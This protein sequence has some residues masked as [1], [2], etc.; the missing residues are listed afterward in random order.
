MKRLLLILLPILMIACNAKKNSTNPGLE[1][2]SYNIS[3][4]SGD[5]V[6]H[7]GDTLTITASASNKVGNQTLTDGFIYDTLFLYRTDHIPLT[8]D[9]LV[10]ESMLDTDFVLIPYTD[11]M[12]YSPYL[13]GSVLKGDSVFLQNDSFKMKFQLV[14]L[15][16]GL[17][18]F[19]TSGGKLS[20]G[21]GSAKVNS[22]ISN[23]NHHYWYQQVPGIDT[24][25]LGTSGYN[26]NYLFTVQ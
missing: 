22:I 3:V 20:S 15:K 10:S 1:A 9:T 24:P 5:S 11:H 25:L 21:L 13:Y 17:Y 26:A 7:I 19:S 14:F 18:I 8:I 16:K 6:L 2:I 12:A 4:A 23:T